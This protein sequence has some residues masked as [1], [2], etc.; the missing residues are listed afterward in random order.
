LS[1]S[2]YDWANHSFALPPMDR[3]ARKL[4]HTLA[5]AYNLSSKSHG[6]GKSR[7]TTLFKTLQ[8]D[9]LPLNEHKIRSI[10]KRSSYMVTSDRPAWGDYAGSLPRAAVKKH[11]E[12]DIVGGDAKEIGLDNR[13]RI[14]LEKLGWRSGMGLGAEGVG[15]RLPIFAVV[16]ASKSGLK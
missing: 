13:G 10:L 4:V 6:A 3:L 9:G 12:G 8:T 11:K 2:F 5:N 16:K 7:F 14:M 15:M 1:I